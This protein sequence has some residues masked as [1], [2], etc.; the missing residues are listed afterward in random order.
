M[1]WFWISFAVLVFVVAPIVGYVIVTL[2]G[3]D[4]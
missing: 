1:T 4:R 2:Y 3:R